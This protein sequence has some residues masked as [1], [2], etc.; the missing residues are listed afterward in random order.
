[1]TDQLSKTINECADKLKGIDN[2]IPPLP[3]TNEPA[4]EAMLHRAVKAWEEMVGEIKKIATVFTVPPLSPP[5]DPMCILDYV[6]AVAMASGFV[7]IGFAIASKIG[8][9]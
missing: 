4:R 6:A 9:S 5:T 2:V 8:S 3:K 1:M 7:C